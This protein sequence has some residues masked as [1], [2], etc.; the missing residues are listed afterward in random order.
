MKTATCLAAALALVP[1]A[2]WGAGLDHLPMITD[3][4]PEAVAISPH[5]PHMGVHYAH[6]ADLPTGPIWCV[7]EGRVVCVEYM[8]M[9]GALAEGQ[10]WTGLV[11]G[12]DTPPIT[13]IDLEYRAEGAGP[14]TDPLYQLHVFFVGADVLAAH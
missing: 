6:P 11:T 10:D 5:V 9:A 14:I 7:I 2:G 8:F 1:C 13:H 12:M 3:I 4:A